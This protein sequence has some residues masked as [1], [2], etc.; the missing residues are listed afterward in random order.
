M[1]TWSSAPDAGYAGGFRSG[2]LCGRLDILPQTWNPF[3]LT[4]RCRVTR[5]AGC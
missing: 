3:I 1:P 4:Q 2:A 5:L